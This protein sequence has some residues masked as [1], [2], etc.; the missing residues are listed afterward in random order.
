MLEIASSDNYYELKMTR[1][2]SDAQIREITSEAITYFDKFDFET[3]IYNKKSD[4]VDVY[5][6][7]INKY[8]LAWSALFEI[9]NMSSQ[10]L[11]VSI[12]NLTENSSHKNEINDFKYRYKKDNF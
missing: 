9:A 6:D 8:P 11:E 3:L 7:T 5:K 2:I 1:R 10:T 4:Y 12:N